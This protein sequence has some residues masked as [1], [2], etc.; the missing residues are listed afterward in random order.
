MPARLPRLHPG[1][2]APAP[3]ACVTPDATASDFFFDYNS[4][5]L[6]ASDKNYLE[7][8]AKAYLSQNIS[9]EIVVKGYASIDGDSNWNE[10]LSNNRATAVTRFLAKKLPKAK[11]KPDGKGPTSS[12]PGDL[13][14][15]RAPRLRRCWN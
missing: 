11:I 7:A 3:D 1:P 13:C 15:N 6:T 10:K 8:Y 5:E 4:A 14:Q 2:G 9:E 12:F